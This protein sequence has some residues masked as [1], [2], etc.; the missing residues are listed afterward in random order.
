MS[1]CSVPDADF[2][3]DAPEANF[4]PNILEASDNLILNVSRPWT[5]VMDF[6][7]LRVLTS[8]MTSNFFFF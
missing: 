2:M 7:L 3:M 4:L 8:I 1:M 5:D 6:F